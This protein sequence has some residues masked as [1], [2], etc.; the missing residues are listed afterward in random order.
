MNFL[1]KLFKFEENNTNFKTELLA[2][3]TTFFTM[4]YLIILSPKILQTTGLDFNATLTITAILV[5]IFSVLMGLY[6]NKP[7]AVA[8]FLGETA[9]I[10]YTVVGTLE[11]SI[12]TAFGAIFICGI[13]LLLMSLFNIREFILNQIPETIK[14]AF[15]TGLGLF[16]MFIALKDME[17]VNFTNNAIPLS[18]GNFTDIHVILGLFCF[19]TLIVLTKKEVKGA[20]LIAIAL[21]TIIGLLIG[22]ITLP[23]RLI[24]IPT[25][26]S[27]SLLQIDFS[28]ILTKNFLPIF[29]VIF[30]LVNIDTSGALIGLSYKTESNPK[31]IKLKKPMIVDSLSVIAAPLMG[32]T[33]PG[34]YFDSMTGIAAGGR[35]GLTAITVG[36]LFLIGLIFAPIIS[37]IPAYAYAPALL[38]IGILIATIITK[39]DFEDI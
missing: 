37:I 17:L 10:A 25:N 11:F 34:A 3:L 5:F 35:T 16:F 6:T 24:S 19:I 15:C 4:S 31:E 32:T 7:Y 2:G 1:T 13:L 22:D 29:F 21:T 26:I 36:I 28:N 27:S 20:I 38:Y 8:P 23:E 39:L 9:F 14:I 18:M 30:L 33:T 12:N